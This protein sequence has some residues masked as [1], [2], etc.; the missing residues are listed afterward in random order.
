MKLPNWVTF[1]KTYHK[2]RGQQGP[3]CGKLKPG[4]QTTGSWA[5]TNCQGCLDWRE[6]HK[7]DRQK[8][9]QKRKAADADGDPL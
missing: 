8:R 3:M 9:Y 1:G 6:L 4:D 2:T 7:N 5:K